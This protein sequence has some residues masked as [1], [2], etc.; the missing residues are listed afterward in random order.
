MKIKQYQV[1][2]FSDRVFAGNPAAICPLNTWLA[3]NIMQAIAAENNLSETAFFVPSAKG[4]ALRWFTPQKEVKLCGHATLAAAHVLFEILA[5]TGRA[6]T[7][8]TLSGDLIV[9]KHNKL[10]RM[11]FPADPPVSCDVPDVLVQALGH[12]PVEVLAAE[13]YL[14]VFESEEII[15]NLTPNQL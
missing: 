12:R 7:F 3:D 6:I 13:D 8:E 9:E 15:R 2:A 10:L 14:V 5:Y 4:Y 1:D 11:D